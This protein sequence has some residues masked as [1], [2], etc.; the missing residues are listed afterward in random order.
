MNPRA[1]HAARL[2]R[3]SG[4][5]TRL[6]RVWGRREV[7]VSHI[8]QSC[9]VENVDISIFR[10]EMKKGISSQIALEFAC[11]HRKGNT[12]LKILKLHGK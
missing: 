4:G 3:E 9:F 6:L 12:L 2:L 1:R 11:T 8:E 10:K 7:R 5:N